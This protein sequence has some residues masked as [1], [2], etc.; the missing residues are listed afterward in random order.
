[1]IFLIP[2]LNSFN[3]GIKRSGDYKVVENGKYN[4]K[5]IGLVLVGATIIVLGLVGMYLEQGPL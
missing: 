1:M 4:Y 2:A 5:Q 3:Y